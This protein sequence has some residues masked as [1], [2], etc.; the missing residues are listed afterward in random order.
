MAVNQRT[1]SRLGAQARRPHRRRDRGRGAR[2]VRGLAARPRRRLRLGR[3][4]RSA[5]PIAPVAASPVATSA[6][7]RSR[8]AGRS[9]GS[10]PRT[11]RSTSSSAPRRTGSTSATCRRTRASG[12]S[13][14]AT[15]RR[16]LS[17]LGRLHGAEEPGEDLR[18][19]VVQRAA[20]CDRRLQQLAADEHLPRLSRAPTCRSRSTTPRRRRPAR[21]SPRGGSSRSV[22][23]GAARLLGRVPAR[24]GGA[25]A[26][27][28]QLLELAAGAKLPRPLLRA[29]RPDRRDPRGAVRHLDGRDRRARRAAGG[30]ARARR[31]TCS[32]RRGARAWRAG[33]GPRR[34]VSSRS[35]PRRSCSPGARPSAATSSSTTPPPTW[36]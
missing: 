8:S 1:R 30:G 31:A 11:A 6:T 16:H 25:L 36:R 17:R 9:T 3:A 34:A 15:A 5:E 21:S 18:R 33:P 4:S 12:R 2:G 26:R 22:A 29:G 27:L 10:G 28:R 24:A 14:R 19:V 35:S 23:D 7:S 20:R 32:R 13:R